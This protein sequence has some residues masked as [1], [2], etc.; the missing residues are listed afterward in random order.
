[1]MIIKKLKRVFTRTGESSAQL[2]T[3]R[4]F[5]IDYLATITVANLCNGIYL[6]GLLRFM[7]FSDSANGTILAIPVLGGLFQ[8]VGPLILSKI[9]NEQP[10]LIYGTF[11]G[12]FSLAAVF[13]VP[14]LLGSTLIGGISVVIIFSIGHCMLAMLAPAMGNWL[15]IV[16]PAR[17][18]SSFFALRERLGLGSIAVAMLIA[19]AFLDYFVSPQQQPIGFA[20][21]G[22]I[23]SILSFA[24]LF[25]LKKMHKP[26]TERLAALT[27]KQMGKM[28]LSR[29]IVKVMGITILWH[30]ATQI[31][32]PH[33]SIYIIETL[34][35]S[36]SFLGI[37]N[38]V[39]SIQK[40]LLMVLWARY[41]S[42][43]S[44]E[45]S[46]FIAVFIYGVSTS[47]YLVMTPGNA[48]IMMIIQMLISA[49]AWA[50]LGVALFN[51]QY[52]NL[53]GDQK[54]LKMGLI[55]GIS[56]VVGFI[57]S[58]LGGSVIVVVDNYGGFI[59]F[60]GQQVVIAIACVACI[61]IMVLLYY[62][63]IPKD[64]RPKISDYTE[65]VVIIVK[66]IEALLKDR[67]TKRK[68]R[69][70]RWIH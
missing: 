41:T 64:K 2:R 35:I 55:G 1:M 67:A 9:K 5:L 14:I 38:T 8:I 19:S 46:F 11:L 57:I 6:A 68:Y 18:R 42:R 52:D 65:Y 40:I 54:V 32:I 33:N 36:Y 12:R 27:I 34:G 21:I 20:L 29:D 53:S 50:I 10:F 59:G 25:A 15:M 49:V 66:R 23:L 16:T 61:G 69:S 60:D 7:G 31:W 58:V 26:N 37:M 44:F 3:R 28:L 24:D 4:G 63:F 48:Y 47:V 56:G 13:F 43:T 62:G 45:H 70:E 39:V 51:V 22:V 17:E 30:V